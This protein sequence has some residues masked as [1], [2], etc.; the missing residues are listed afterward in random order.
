VKEE[1]LEPLLKKIGARLIELRKKK[2]YKSHETFCYDFNIPRMQ[3]WRM[4]N[5][6]TNLTLRSLL[7]I[8]AIHKITFEDFIKQLSKETTNKLF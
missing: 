2:G 3:Y 6:R 5:G 1:A 8:L 7:R 4:E